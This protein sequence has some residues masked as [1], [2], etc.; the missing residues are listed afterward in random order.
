[1]HPG[2]RSCSRRHR[3]TSSPAA[4]EARGRVIRD[5]QVAGQWRRTVSTNGGT[6]DG[7]MFLTVDEPGDRVCPVALGL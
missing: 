5:S 6:V 2:F 7:Q 1:M 3:W 4:L